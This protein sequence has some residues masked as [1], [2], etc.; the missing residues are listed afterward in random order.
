MNKLR[1]AIY[2]RVST[3]EQAQ[4][5][6][7]KAQEEV[8]KEYAERKGYELY[9]VYCDDGYSGK[10]FN[11]PEIQRLFKDLYNDKVDAILVWKIDRLSRNNSDVLT[12]IDKQLNPSN[13]KVVITSID[14]DS[15]TTTG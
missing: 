6:S 4:N 9:D 14:M 7:L 8:V 10:D 11:R 3:E 15:S 2:I 12:L 5:F 1:A 13:K